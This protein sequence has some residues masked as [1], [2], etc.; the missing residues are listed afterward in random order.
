ACASRPC[1]LPSI[2]TASCASR[3]FGPTPPCGILYEASLVH[4]W[5]YAAALGMNALHP[6]YAE[7]MIIERSEV[8]QAH[9]LHL[10]VNPWIVDDAEAIRECIRLGCDRIISNYPDRAVAILNEEKAACRA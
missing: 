3:R 5:R 4:P 6:H 2:I 8:D 10:E 9:S 7:P 1:I